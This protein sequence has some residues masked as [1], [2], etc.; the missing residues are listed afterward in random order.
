MK[1]GNRRKINLKSEGRIARRKIE[2]E[3]SENIVL[4]NREDE[5]VKRFTEEKDKK[6]NSIVISGLRIAVT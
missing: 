3:K 2:S 5:R 1:N 6:R 4:K